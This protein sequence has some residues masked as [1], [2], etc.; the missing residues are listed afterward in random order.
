MTSEKPKPKTRFRSAAPILFFADTKV[1][2]LQIN[3]SFI[4]Q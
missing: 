1:A 3:S 2:L 4:I